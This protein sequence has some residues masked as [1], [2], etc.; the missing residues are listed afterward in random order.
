M[1]FS[2]TL[3]LRN[4]CWCLLVWH[5]FSK[6][7][8]SFRDIKMA[9][10]KLCSIATILNK[11]DCNSKRLVGGYSE[12]NLTEL[13]KSEKEL[14][15]S[16]TMLTS[17]D[18]LTTICEHHERYFSLDKQAI[19]IIH[20]IYIQ[21]NAKVN[22]IISSLAASHT[23]YIFSFS[24]SKVISLSLSRN[25]LVI[26]QLIVGYKLC[27]ECYQHAASL[28]VKKQKNDNWIGH[29]K[30]VNLCDYFRFHFQP[31][32]AAS[33][34]LTTPTTSDQIGAVGVEYGRRNI[35]STFKNA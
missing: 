1:L 3:K 28:N 4:L 19:V 16:R 18:N 12:R 32:A 8:C 34:L 7:I 6:V 31:F 22:I 29:L 10:A 13:T 24:A 11:S 27:I 2:I 26:P 23:N 33:A 15:L 30:R 20:S 35:S 14:L 9:E 17:L 5:F 21:T 25:T